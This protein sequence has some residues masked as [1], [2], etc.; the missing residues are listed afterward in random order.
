MNPADKL[1]RRKEEILA[2][3]AQLGPMRKG[4]ISK[5]YMDA[6][7]KDGSKRRRG[8]YALYT[9]KDEGRTVSKRLTP[10]QAES[11]RLQIENY[12]SFQDL[13]REL[14]QIGQRLAD[15]EA[16]GEKQDSKKNSR[17]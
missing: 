10:A 4:S 11:Y 8:P 2:Q 6:V 5:Q 12:R 3:I 13:T 9:C 14:A 15:I 16:R 1:I 17:R 7:L